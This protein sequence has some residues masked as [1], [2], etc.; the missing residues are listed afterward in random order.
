MTGEEIA[1]MELSSGSQKQ[2][3]DMYI[4]SLIYVWTSENIKNLNLYYASC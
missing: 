3:A 1:Q 2:Y 4:E